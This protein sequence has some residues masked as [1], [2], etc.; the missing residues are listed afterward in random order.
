[1]IDASFSY[2]LIFSGTMIDWMWFDEKYAENC[3][4]FYLNKFPITHYHTSIYQ[5]QI[6]SDPTRTKMA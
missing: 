6:T 3:T 1:M 4:Y 2:F 5:I